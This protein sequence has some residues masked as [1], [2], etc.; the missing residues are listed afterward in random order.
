M[1]KVY[2]D[3]ICEYVGE[4]T[5]LTDVTGG[6]E[7]S[8]YSPSANGR[9]IG[10]R[11]ITGRQAVTSLINHVNFELTCTA[12]TPNALRVGATGTGLQTAPAFQAEPVDYVVDQPVNTGT[13]I[14]I[15]AMCIGDTAVTNSTF[16]YGKFEAA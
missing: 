6:A 12:W 10:L 16:L 7:A 3:L 14:K 9:L 15:K 1:A 11:V 8:P 2:W 13:Q 4:D 5:T